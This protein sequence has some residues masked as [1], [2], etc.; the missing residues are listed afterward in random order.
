VPT[1]ALEPEGYAILSGEHIN[2]T[3][4]HIRAAT[5]EAKKL[6]SAVLVTSPARCNVVDVDRYVQCYSLA[7]CST[8][9]DLV[10]GC[11]RLIWT[12][13]QSGKG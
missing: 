6:L 10:L 8:C 2:N 9:T 11:H 4:V 1:D 5:E 3:V 13:Q 7:R 12:G